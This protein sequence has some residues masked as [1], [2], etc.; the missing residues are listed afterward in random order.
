[1]NTMLNLLDGGPGRS[2]TFRRARDL[3][4]SPLPL[5]LWDEKEIFAGSLTELFMEAL[6]DSKDNIREVCRR[7]RL[8][9]KTESDPETRLRMELALSNLEVAARGKTAQ[10]RRGPLEAAER[11]LAECP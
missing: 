8:L 4:P 2:V 5:S 9:I 10:D 3:V 7:L 6:M 1:M 11:Q